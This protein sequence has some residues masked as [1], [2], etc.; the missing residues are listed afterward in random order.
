M[1]V[2]PIFGTAL[3][4]IFLMIKMYENVYDTVT[5]ISQTGANVK[6]FDRFFDKTPGFR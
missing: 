6:N 2:K 5:R 3:D 1:E 4:I